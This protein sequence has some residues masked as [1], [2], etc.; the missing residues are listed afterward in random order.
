MPIKGIYIPK[1]CTG[2]FPSLDRVSGTLPVTLRDRDISLVQF[3]P[4]AA[5]PKKYNTTENN[6]V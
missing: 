6:A 2:V 5:R 3:N 1:L 4:F